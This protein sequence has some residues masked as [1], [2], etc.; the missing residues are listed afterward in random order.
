MYDTF[1]L[2]SVDAGAAAIIS[3]SALLSM[4]HQPEVPTP[5]GEG[6]FACEFPTIQRIVGFVA[7]RHHL[8]SAERQDFGSYVTLKLLEDD[9]AILRKHQGRSSMRT[10]LSTVIARLFLDFRI[11]AWGK[12]RPSAAARR[13]GPIGV[14]FEQLTTRDG[15]S[16]EEAFELLRT[17][18]RLELERRDIDELVARL[19][20]RYR[21]RF[22]SEDALTKI[23]AGRSP[24]E[25]ALAREAERLVG[26]RITDSLRGTLADLDPEDQLLL[27]MRFED[28]CTVSEIAQVLRLDQKRL[29]RRLDHLLDVLRDSL[30]RDGITADAV[31]DLLQ[32]ATLALEWPLSVT[33]PERRPLSAVNEKQCL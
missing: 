18:Y 29:Y 19:P 4:A 3:R 10:Y 11:A 2:D 21:R 15:Y 28:G 31:T 12:W 26:D 7:S 14:L 24:A 30:E 13:C 8:S 17:N 27:T 23:G 25:E 32:R 33:E 6:L 22:E 20:V 5:V 9:Y 1:A 16:V